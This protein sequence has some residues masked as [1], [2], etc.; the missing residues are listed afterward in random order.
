MKS[1]QCCE[2]V[3]VTTLPFLPL[4]CGDENPPDYEF[5]FIEFHTCRSIPRVHVAVKPRPRHS[6]VMSAAAANLRLLPFFFKI[7]LVVI[8]HFILSCYV[9]NVFKFSSC[10]NVNG[11]LAFTE[12]R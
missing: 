2:L 4:T 9:L 8:F 11:S 6:P 1:L 10:A 3:V 7:I 5:T 12:I